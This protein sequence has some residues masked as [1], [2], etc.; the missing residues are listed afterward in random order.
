MLAAMP[1][2]ID[3]STFAGL[4]T[5]NHNLAAWCPGCCRWATCDLKMLVRNG[6]D[7]R[8]IHRCRPRC[9]ICGSLGEWQLRALVPSLDRQSRRRVYL[10]LSRQLRRTVNCEECHGQTERLE[11]FDNEN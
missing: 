3:L 2:I 10:S 6:L 8:Q 9:R 5:R 1:E 7:D 11:R 4:L